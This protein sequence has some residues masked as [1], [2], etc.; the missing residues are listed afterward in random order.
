MEDRRKL[1]K[2][3][4]KLAQASNREN[5]CEA[6]FI[7]IEVNIFRRSSGRIR[8][9]PRASRSKEI[10]KMTSITQSKYFS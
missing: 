7:D 4:N 6:A 3:N 9:G 8:R 2:R 5:L 10:I 1:E